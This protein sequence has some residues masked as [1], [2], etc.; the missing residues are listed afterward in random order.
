MA[1]LDP[2]IVARTASREKLPIFSLGS[3]W[4]RRR[5]NAANPL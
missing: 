5:S 3:S 2:G 4:A 1:G